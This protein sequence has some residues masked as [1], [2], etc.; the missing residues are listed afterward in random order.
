L[1]IFE[2]LRHNAYSTRIS[3]PRPRADQ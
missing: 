3:P 1:T 2:L